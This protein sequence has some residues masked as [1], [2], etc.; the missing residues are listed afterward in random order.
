MGDAKQSPGGEICL[1]EKRDQAFV[2]YIEVGK[3]AKFATNA[4]P[5]VGFEQ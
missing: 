5:N 3:R 1:T 2:P 4:C